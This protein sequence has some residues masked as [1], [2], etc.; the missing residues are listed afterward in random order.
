MKIDFHAHILPGADHGASR[1]ETSLRQLAL[2]REAGVSAVVATPHFYPH[3]QTPE[4]FLT[5]RESAIAAL[6]E[7]LPQDAPTVYI[8]AEVLVC[9]GIHEMEGLEKL[10]IEGT[11]VLLLEMPTT[12]WDSAILDTVE[13]IKVITYPISFY[14]I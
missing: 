11:N 9:P 1:V 13:E 4:S 12:V 10:T 7:A 2:M 6:R 5:K 14:R 8:G 3:R